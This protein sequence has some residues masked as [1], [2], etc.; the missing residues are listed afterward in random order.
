V[1][2][3]GSVVPLFERQM[4]EGLLTITDE[5]MTRFWITLPQAVDLVFYALEHSVGGEIF[6]PKIP[7]MKVTDLAEAMA[8][9]VPV[10]IIGIRPGEKLHEVLITDD[11]SRHTIDAGDVFVVLPEHPWWTDHPRWVSGSPLS[12]GFIYAS[13]TN[14]EWLGPDELRRVLDA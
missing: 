6:I 3:R 7:S 5:R 8:P 4:A 13:N 9:G 11:E 10:K 2:S 12:D 1:G 14:D